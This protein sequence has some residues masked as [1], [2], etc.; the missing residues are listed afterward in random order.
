[1][2]IALMAGG[3]PAL[4]AIGTPAVS[5]EES[6]KIALRETVSVDYSGAGI[7]HTVKLTAYN[8]VPEQTDEDPFTTASGARSNPEVIAAVSRDLW[9]SDMPKGTVVAVEYAG[10]SNN[11]GF[12]KVEHL[13]G[14]RVIADTMNKR[15]TNKMDILLDEA[16]TVMIAVNGKPAAETNPAKALGLCT[17]TVRVVGQIDVKDIPETQQE[18]KWLVE[19]ADTSAAS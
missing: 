9:S 1:M 18:L 19:D 10:S 8:A 17:V 15:F 12:A 14:Y 2:G 16:D 3:A 4:P 6:A 5:A 11:C 7:E 13:I